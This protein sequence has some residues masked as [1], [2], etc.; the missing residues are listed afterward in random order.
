MIGDIGQQAWGALKHNQRRSLL[1]MLGMA[2]GIATV[3]LLLAYGSG[4]ERGLWVAF[5]TFGTNLVFVFPGRTSLQA[6][7]TKAG[8]EV[9][10]TLQD[11][12]YVRNEV[13][14]LKRVSPE[15]SKQSLVAYGTRSASYPVS[16]VYSAYARMR[17]I[18]VAEGSFFGEQ[19]DFAHTRVA[20][21]GADIK[22][23][24]FSGQDALGQFVRLDGISFEVVGV[25]KHVI[26]NG[27]E[28]MNGKVYVPFS[29]MGDLKNTYYLNAI[30]M[31]YEGSNE[32]VVKALRNSMAFHHEFDPK[33]K[34]AVFVFDVFS[35]L[36]DLRVITTGIK[37][38]LGFIGL[39][40]LGI[41]GV[42]LM[43]IM[44]VSVT[45]RTRE[46][47][48][49]KALGARRWHILLQFL[50]EALAITA[51]GGLAGVLIAYV[52]SWSVGSLTLWSAFIEDATEGDI[53]LLIDSSTL[54]AATVI[55]SFVGIISGMLPAIKAARLDPIEALRYE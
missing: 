48:V 49:E 35:D 6:G 37:I 23:K 32:K 30:V 27:D 11:L 5:R 36:L 7:G 25:M 21:I 29:A 40:T 38:L 8:T 18:E 44:L 54:I 16:G 34:R 33:D 55:L 31:E 39:L 13:P 19:E 50:T 52:I 1:T 43:N 4:F 47:G 10:L 9:R 51:L 22:K 14:L 12:D 2:W 24:L 3:V 20:I 42:G 17:K 28:N 45:Q 46:I 53:R 41:G 15:S 26:Q